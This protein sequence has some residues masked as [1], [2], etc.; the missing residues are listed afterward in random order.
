MSR[1]QLV[2][3]AE[4]QEN[5]ADFLR[6][7]RKKQKLSREALAERSGV[8]APT[9]KKFELTGQISL[10]QF[11]LLWQCLDDLRR[12][13]DLTQPRAKNQAEPR[14]LDEVLNS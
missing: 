11:V 7:E 10:R 5:L 8:P 1:L 14:T 13:H 12:L 9:L 2:A 3:P 4:V 6:L